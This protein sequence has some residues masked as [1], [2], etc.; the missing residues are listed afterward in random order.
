MTYAMIKKTTKLMPLMRH[1]RS[2]NTLV[3]YALVDE[4][5][6]M[7]DALMRDLLSNLR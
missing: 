6:A 3:V 2:Q 1:K 5:L 4:V 7:V